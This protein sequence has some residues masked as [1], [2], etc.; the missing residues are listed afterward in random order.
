MSYGKTYVMIFVGNLFQRHKDSTLLMVSMEDPRDLILERLQLG[1]TK[2]GHGVRVNDDTVTW[3]TKKDSW[4]HMAKEEFL[5]GMIY[6][7]ADYIR[8]GRESPKLV[9]YLE[10]VYMYTHN[11]VRSEDDNDLILFILKRIYMIESPM[12]K[13]VLK[14]LVNMLYFCS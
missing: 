12:H 7:I 1:K 8:K 9:S 5:D 2:Y 13:H 4:M 3:G 14:S 10:F 11:F 6:V